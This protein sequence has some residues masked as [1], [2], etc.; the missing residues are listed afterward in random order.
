MDVVPQSIPL[1]QALGER[2][3]HADFAA[4]MTTQAGAAGIDLGGEAEEEEAM[5]AQREA[6][7]DGEG[8]Q[9]GE[10][11]RA[12]NGTHSDGPGND[13][14]AE[15]QMMEHNLLPS[16]ARAAGDAFQGTSSAVEVVSPR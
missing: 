5:S 3:K 7:D 8:D 1:S 16:T 4:S 6:D 10:G 11:A 14:T 9:A 12:T 15:D 13:I 2:Q